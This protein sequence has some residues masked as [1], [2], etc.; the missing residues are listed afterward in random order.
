MLCSILNTMKLYT[1]Y[2]IMYTLINLP[3]KQHI[4]HIKCICSLIFRIIYVS[5]DDY[6]IL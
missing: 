6:T 5:T 2:I 4:K 3:P 1:Y